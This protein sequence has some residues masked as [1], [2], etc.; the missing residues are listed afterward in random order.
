MGAIFSLDHTILLVRNQ[1]ESVEFYR[2]VMGFGHEGKAGPF[3][4]MRINTG[5]TLDLLQ[6]A[7]ADPVHLAF[8]VDPATFDAVHKRLIQHNIPFGGDTFQ[9]DGRIAANPFGARGMADALYFYDPDR[10]NLELRVYR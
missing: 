5:F 8:S 4:V 9:R 3:E 1:A 7:P 2:Q 10:H 6:Q